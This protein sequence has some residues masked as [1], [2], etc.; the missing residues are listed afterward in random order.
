MIFH[1]AVIS[2][3]AGSVIVSF[4]M[5]YSSWFGSAILRKWNLRS[6]SELQLN[7]ERR[8]YLI[9]TILSYVFG[10]Q[11]ISFFLFIFT[12]DHLHGLFTGAMCAAGTLNVNEYG[13]PA[14]LLKMVNFILA[15]LWLVMNYTDNRAFD[16]PLIRTK[17]SMLLILAPLLVV[18]TLVQSE[19]FLGLKAEVITSCCGSLFGADSGSIASDIAAFPHR[20]LKTAFYGSI[21]ATSFTGVFFYLKGGRSGVVFSALSITA[22]LLS[23]A[24]L[25]SF[26]SPYVYELPTH[27]C[28]FCVLQREY[29]YI[30]YLL[31]VGLLAA[32]V[33]GAGVGLLM[34]FRRIPSLKEIIPS[35]QKK[36]TLSSVLFF[37]L[38]AG[39]ATYKIVFSGL[40]MEGY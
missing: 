17:Y 39:L 7:L 30:G 8:T 21:I 14:I 27:H 2:L 25:I 19:Y 12:A 37:L 28:P 38:F 16:Y 4:M 33:S 32:V 1:P 35:I 11:L 36:L 40:K 9:S 5:L 18:E 10:F 26:I 15:G 22:F 24:S 20:P 23:I 29:G 6:G 3:S 34:P 31:Y 13:Y